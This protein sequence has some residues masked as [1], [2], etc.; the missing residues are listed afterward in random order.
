M[1]FTL[2]RG[3]E[4]DLFDAA[5]FYRT[6]GGAALA[7]RFVDEFERV[8]LLLVEHPGFGTPIDAQ[9]RVFPMRGFPYSLIYRPQ[10]GDVRILVLRHQHRDPDHGKG[11]R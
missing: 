8:A 9:R 4:Q 7:Q 1:S 2:H 11:R 3:A 6:E 5:S 10:D